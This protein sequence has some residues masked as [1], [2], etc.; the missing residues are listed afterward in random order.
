MR[1]F[2]FLSR[3]R[4]RQFFSRIAEKICRMIQ[5][6]LPDG[7]WLIVFAR[8]IAAFDSLQKWQ[9]SRAPAAGSRPQ[10]NIGGERPM[11]F[12]P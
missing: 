7:V 6:R 8:P 3:K 11:A 5:G 1:F 2:Q 4:R 12:P 10:R 9:L